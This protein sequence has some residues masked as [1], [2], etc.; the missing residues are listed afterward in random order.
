MYPCQPE[1]VTYSVVTSWSPS[2]DGPDRTSTNTLT[3][4]VVRHMGEQ[5]MSLPERIPHARSRAP[6]AYYPSQTL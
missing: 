1:M 3:A 2:E 4:V 5:V 6:L